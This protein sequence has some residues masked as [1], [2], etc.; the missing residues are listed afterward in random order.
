M[1]PNLRTIV[2]TQYID[3][4][5]K[6][7]TSRANGTKL[8]KMSNIQ[9]NPTSYRMTCT[10]II[11][12]NDIR[13][14]KIALQH[15]TNPNPKWRY[16]NYQADLKYFPNKTRHDHVTSFGLIHLIVRT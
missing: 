16:S 8:K 2:M 15:D 12:T 13:Q 3:N 9:K 11:Y 7:T 6:H 4:V 5:V 14:S 10:M 1:T